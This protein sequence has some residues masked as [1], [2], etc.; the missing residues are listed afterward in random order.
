M[1]FAWPHPH[2]MHAILLLSI[3]AKERFAG[4]KRTG[5]KRPAYLQAAHRHSCDQAKGI[6]WL[7]LTGFKV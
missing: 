7:S 4:L 2:A 6:K 5:E 3:V 1:I